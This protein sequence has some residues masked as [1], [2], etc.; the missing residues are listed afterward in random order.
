MQEIKD[1]CEWA[2]NNAKEVLLALPSFH[3][4][5]IDSVDLDGKHLIIRYDWFLRVKVSVPEPVLPYI[6]EKP[7][8][9]LVAF[10]KD[11]E[12]TE[13]DLQIKNSAA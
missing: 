1:Q 2:I 6:L 7:S 5:S 12:I 9:L 13:I 3:Q 8:I 4:N 10:N 11:G